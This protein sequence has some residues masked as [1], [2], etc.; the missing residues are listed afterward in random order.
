MNINVKPV[1]V[2][3]PFVISYLLISLR[4]NFLDRR[5]LWAFLKQVTKIVIE[6]KYSDK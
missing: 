1:F 3:I 6:T 5:V 2:A 4:W